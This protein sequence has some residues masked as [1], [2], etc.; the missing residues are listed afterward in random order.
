MKPLAAVACVGLILGAGL[1]AQQRP[2]GESPQWQTMIAD[3]FKD[4]ISISIFNL[5]GKYLKPPAGNNSPTPRLSISCSGGK[6][7]G[8]NIEF[9]TGIRFLKG[10]T[11]PGA[12][13]GGQHTRVMMQWDDQK[14]AVEEQGELLNE[15]QS[16]YLDQRQTVKLLTGHGMGSSGSPHAYV[17]RQ[18][19]SIAE[20]SGNRIVMEFDLPKD[21]QGI[22]GTCGLQAWIKSR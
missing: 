17:R 13:K 2:P 12:A 22:E 5:D 20:A 6:L 7:G 11:S 16:V 21:S 3:D 9:G 8:V 1:L 19:I 4:R 14:A 15:G 18:T 10:S